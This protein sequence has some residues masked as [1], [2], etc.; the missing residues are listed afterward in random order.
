ME[1]KKYRKTGTST[2]KGSDSKTHTWSRD[3]NTDR[4]PEKESDSLGNEICNKMEN[5]TRM[6]KGISRRGNLKVRTIEE[7]VETNQLR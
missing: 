4:K 6:D 1:R 2:G 7:E 5:K 3:I